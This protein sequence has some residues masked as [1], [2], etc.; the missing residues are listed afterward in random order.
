MEFYYEFETRNGDAEWTYEVDTTR[1]IEELAKLVAKRLDLGK[2]AMAI[3][4][5][6]DIISEHEL[7]NNDDFMDYYYEELQEVF[8]SDAR[9]DFKDNEGFLEDQEDWFGTKNNIW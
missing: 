6:S 2:D 5:A 7:Y 1:V 9:E 3:K 4:L 8:E